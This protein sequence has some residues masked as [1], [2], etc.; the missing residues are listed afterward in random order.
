MGGGKPYSMDLRERVAGAVNE[1]RLS[2]HQAAAQFAWASTR[3]FFGFDG[4]AR[5]AA[6]HPVRWAGTS[7]RRFRASTAFGCWNA[8]GQGTSLCADWSH[9][10]P[11]RV[12]DPKRKSFGASVGARD[13]KALRAEIG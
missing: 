11:S 12:R 9:C 1:G 13:P 5:R 3:P 4:S 6:L 8:P 2:C 10:D 7:R